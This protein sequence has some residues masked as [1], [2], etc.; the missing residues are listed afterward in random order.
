[1]SAVALRESAAGTAMAPVLDLLD[2]AGCTA[3]AGTTPADA[4]MAAAPV[5]APVARANCC[6]CCSIVTLRDAGWLVLLLGCS[7]VPL[8]LPGTLL[9][10]PSATWLLVP[11]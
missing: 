11:G 1:M 5:V 3:A 8:R 10:L 9:Q 4:A 7:A 6:I 2:P